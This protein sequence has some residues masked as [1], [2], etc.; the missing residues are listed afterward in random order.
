MAFRKYKLVF[1]NSLIAL[2]INFLINYYFIPLYGI[3]AAAAST[4]TAYAF[5]N[6]SSAFLSYHLSVKDKN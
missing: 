2:I 3:I 1:I 4:F 5:I 6:T